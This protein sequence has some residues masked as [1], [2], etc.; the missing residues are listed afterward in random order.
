MKANINGYTGLFALIGSPVKHSG[1]PI[2]YN[3]S[4]QKLNLNYVYLAFD[5]SLGKTADALKALKLLKAKGFHVTMPCKTMMASLVDKL[6]PEAE[7]IGACNVVRIDDDG[8]TIGYNTDGIAFVENLAEHHILVKDKKIVLLGAGG[9]G[10]AVAIQLALNNIA[11]I[12]IFNR[13]DEFWSNARKTIDKIKQIKPDIQTHLY[14]LNEQEKLH[15]AIKEADILINATKVGMKPL[16]TQSL[17]NP[18]FLH[19]HLVVADTVYNPRETLLLE[20]A[21]KCHC[22]AVID[23]LG[24]LLWQGA[25]SFKLFTQKE[26]PR[27]EILDRFFK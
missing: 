10:T 15:E 27:Q 19:E 20:Q 13:Q 8:K 1:S 18:Q 3:Y 23:G 16:D 24:M 12:S 21:K 11:Q 4:F 9:A 22:K 14:D 7:L 2:M 6:T 17:I 5:V 26:M 25:I